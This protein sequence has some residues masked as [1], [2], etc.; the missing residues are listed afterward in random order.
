ML[1]SEDQQCNGTSTNQ[2]GVQGLIKLDRVTEGPVKP[3]ATFLKAQPNGNHN[4]IVLTALVI[5]A[6]VGIAIYVF[7]PQ[8]RQWIFSHYIRLFHKATPQVTPSGMFMG[9]PQQTSSYARVND[10]NGVAFF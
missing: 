3:E 2:S 1:K 8:V 4:L 6:G 9:L 7:N 10:T 5:V